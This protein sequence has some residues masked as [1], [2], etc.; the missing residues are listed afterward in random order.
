MFA[1]SETTGVDNQMNYQH[2]RL[3]TNILNA[4]SVFVVKMTF[5]CLI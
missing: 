1:S 3:T 2:D 5:Y 4:D